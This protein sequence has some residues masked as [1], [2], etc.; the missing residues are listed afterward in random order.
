MLQIAS[1]NNLL[2][3]FIYQLPPTSCLGAPSVSIPQARHGKTHPRQFTTVASLVFFQTSNIRAV[4]LG[5]PFLA[6]ASGEFK[7]LCSL[8]EALTTRSRPLVS[9]GLAHGPGQCNTHPI[10]LYVRLPNLL[11]GQCTMTQPSRLTHGRIPNLLQQATTALGCLPADLFFSRSQSRQVDD[12]RR[13]EHPISSR[14]ESEYSHE[15]SES[16]P[17][18]SHPRG[19]PY[20]PSSSNQSLF[21]SDSATTY[22]ST[23]SSESPSSS[24]SHSSN[25]YS[26]LV[27]QPTSAPITIPVT[28]SKSSSSSSSYY[29]EK[30]C[31]ACPQ[32][33][34]SYWSTQCL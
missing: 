5:I 6:M 22:A 8:L 7:N 26:F 12:S 11:I 32:S 18:L 13:R 30:A 28:R 27:T 4:F 16:F 1:S 25:D 23:T 3:H 9:L 20:P 15:I 29:E 21:T 10:T 24:G 34:A 31:R 2:T 17:L 19:Q 33:P 14:T